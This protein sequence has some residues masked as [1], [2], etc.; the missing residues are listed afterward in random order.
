MA[1]K[2]ESA[3]DYLNSKPKRPKKESARD[4]LN[5]KPKRPKKETA[6]DYLNSKP[7]KP[8]KL[9]PND[10]KKESARDY[11]KL[12]SQQQTLGEI[13]SVGS[14][15][16][17]TRHYNNLDGSTD[18]S[19]RIDLSDITIDDA[20]YTAGD[21][22]REIDLSDGWFIAI[23]FSWIFNDNNESASFYNSKFKNAGTKYERIRQNVNAN[24]SFFKGRAKE[25]L[26]P[27]VRQVAKG[28]RRRKIR[29]PDY[30]TIKIVR[31]KNGRRP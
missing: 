19:I 29:K 13:L 3:R 20:S 25:H 17:E 2:K 23:T 15:L 22:L 11:L 12:K 18:V 24:T 10:Q 31:T 9:V 21:A 7:K 1:S 5:S 27:V 26:W 14:S 16:G 8:K 28:I 4:Y 6:R 30:L